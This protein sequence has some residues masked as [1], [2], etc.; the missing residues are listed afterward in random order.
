MAKERWTEEEI[1]EIFD[2]TEPNNRSWIGKIGHYPPIVLRGQKKTNSK[3]STVIHFSPVSCRDKNTFPYELC[4]C[5]RRSKRGKYFY[6]HEPHLP[7]NCP[8]LD[9]TKEDS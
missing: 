7:N 9:Y 8:F 2:E 3:T 6:E 1:E 5:I 4:R